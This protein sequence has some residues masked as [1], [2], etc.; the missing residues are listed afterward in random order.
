MWVK[1]RRNVPVECVARGYL[2]GSGWKD[3]QQ[4]GALCG[5]PLPAGPAR[6]RRASGAHL[7]SRHQGP[8]RPRREHFVRAIAAIVGAETAAKLRDLTLTIYRKAADYARTRGI[9]IADT[10]FEFG[11]VD[12]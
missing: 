4:T 3:Y 12:G 2:S 6:I 10:K 5:I 1:P 11:M 8:D 9:I 7:H